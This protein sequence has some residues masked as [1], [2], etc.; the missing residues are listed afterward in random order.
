MTTADLQAIEDRLNIKLPGSYRAIMA[1]YPFSPDSFAAEAMLLDEVDAVVDLNSAGVVIQGVS[2]PFFI[3]SDLG[4]EWYF[5][6]PAD[7]ESPVF[8]YEL[9]T[10]EHRVLDPS[11]EKYCDRVRAMEREI[12][13]E[14]KAEMDR[15][16]GKKWWAFWK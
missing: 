3:G 15:K 16:P 4:E 8:V 9:E 1:A 11:L 2:R 10:G 7:N 12:E 14:E 5:L 13:A 6:D